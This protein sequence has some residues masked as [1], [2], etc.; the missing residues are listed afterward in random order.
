MSKFKVVVYGASGYTGKLIC[1][2]LAERRI[3]FIATGRN[4][5]RLEAE[6]ARVP[7]LKGRDY[8]AWRSSMRWVL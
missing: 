8:H 7:E 6:M 3:P 2:K 1:W 5:A 4:G